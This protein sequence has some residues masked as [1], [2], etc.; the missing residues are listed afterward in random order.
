MAD[1]NSADEKDVMIMKITSTT[2]AVVSGRFRRSEEG[3]FSEAHRLFNAVDGD[4]DDDGGGG[5]D[6]AGAGDSDGGK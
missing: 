1:I 6:V 5:D 4:D 2:L 3:L